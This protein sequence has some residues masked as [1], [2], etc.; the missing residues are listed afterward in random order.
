M[1]LPPEVEWPQL[2]PGAP[3][4]VRSFYEGC[5]EGVLKSFDAERAQHAPRKFTIIGNE[6]I[7]KSAFGAYLL[8][9]AVQARRTVVDVS[10]KLLDGFILQGTGRVEAFDSEE[11]RRRAFSV[12]GDASTVLICDGLKPPFCPA[13]TALITSPVR[14][15]W[16]QLDKCVDARRLFFPVFS[17]REID[18]MRRA[19]FPELSDAG[20]EAGVQERF[21]KWGGIPRYVLS[22]LDKGSQ[23][24]L[25]RTTRCIDVGALLR[26]LDR[27]EESNSALSHFLSHLKPAGERADGSSSDPHSA[28]SYLFAR[29]ELGSTH[30]VEAVLRDADAEEESDLEHLHSFLPACADARN[31]GGAGASAE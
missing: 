31:R 28:D 29:S 8:W 23:D 2:G 30:I 9:R 3:L 7:G 5:F 22:K 1:R 4:F 11:F 13:F 15:R 18:D 21:D 27:G 6:G 16:K 14:E 19:C 10:D 20:A 26:N 17:R 12:L 24:L 25:A